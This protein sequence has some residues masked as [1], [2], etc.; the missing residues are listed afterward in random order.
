MVEPSPEVIGGYVVARDGFSYLG[1]GR[2][3]AEAVADATRRAGG[4]PVSPD[5]AQISMV[6]VGR[7]LAEAVLDHGMD[8]DEAMRLAG[9]TLIPGVPLDIPDADLA[10]AK[11]SSR[12]K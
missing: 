3:E 9:Q 7:R 5:D 1:I 2:T 6:L 10:A 8:L 4:V 12:Q 11:A